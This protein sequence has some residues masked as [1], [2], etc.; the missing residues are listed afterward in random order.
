MTAE[1]ILVTGGARSG[2]SAFAERYAA[3]YGKKIA[4][5]ATAQIY[6]HEMRRRVDLH[7][8]RRP[9]DWTTYEA[10][11]EAEKAIA[12]AA[13]AHDTIL[14]DCLTLYISNML[15]AASAPNDADQR[16]AE[17]E[18]H[19]EALI[20]HAK[21]SGRRVIFV[22]NE[23]GMGIVPENALAREYRDLAGLANQRV[24]RCAD[25]VYLVASGIPVDIK[26][27]SALREV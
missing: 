4:Y 14:F 7:Q 9:R 16:H 23:V 15:C 2:K 19:V 20:A 10:P 11:C 24:A 18:R 27:L 6:D 1:V 5:I 21:K 17:M 8:A 25:A 12:E 13:K 26:K 22:T 3:R